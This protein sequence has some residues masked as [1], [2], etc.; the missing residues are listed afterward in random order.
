M[1]V[2][3]VNSILICTM[4]VT[5]RWHGVRVVKALNT[6]LVSS[7][8]GSPVNRLAVTATYGNDLVQ[9]NCPGKRCAA[10]SC[11]QMY[12]IYLYDIYFILYIYIC[13]CVH[14]SNRPKETEHIVESAKASQLPVGFR[15]S[16]C[17]K[18]SN[19]IAMASNLLVM[20]SILTIVKLCFEVQ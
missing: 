11:R 3:L 20:A 1:L 12:S 10:K 15:S 17:Q 7:R 13:V 4:Q 19:L 14:G 5:T 8:R 16:H 6:C 18:M 9:H 2:E